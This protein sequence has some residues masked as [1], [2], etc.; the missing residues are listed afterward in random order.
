[1]LEFKP[2]TLDSADNIIKYLGYKESRTCDSTIG[3]L[4]MWRD[5]YKSEYAIYNDMLYMKVIFA[6]NENR[7]IVP[8]GEHTMKSSM[9]VL[10]EYANENNL[11]LSFV[12]VPEEAL[13]KLKDY[14]Q[15]QLEYVSDRDM[16]D[17]LYLAE[18]LSE[19]K[20]RRYSGQRN[21][22]NKFKKLYPDYKYVKMDSENI[23][24]VMDFY[25][26]YSKNMV[27]TMETAIEENER[28]LEILPFLDKFYMSG[29]FIEVDGKII[30]ISAGEIIKDTLYVHIEKA[31]KEYPGSYQMI[32]N[33]FAKH[34]VFEQ[35]VYIN[36]EDDAGDLGLRTSKLSYHPC[37]IMDK[38]T[39]I[40]KNSSTIHN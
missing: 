22:I 14:Y 12:A 37:K 30:A 31:L 4:F 7:F 26:E 33:E 39:V 24:R 15:N 21:H 23:T 2:I 27:K 6:E 17:Y 16:S 5:Y 13:N 36:R 10:E 8:I 34:N 1:M 28:T 25:E 11:S 32:M 38:Y 29:G 20:G 19:L 3:S 40:I 18:D 35:V 9:P